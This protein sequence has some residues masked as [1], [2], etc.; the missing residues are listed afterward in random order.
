MSARTYTL[1]LPYG[2]VPVTVAERG[3][4]APVLLLHGGAGPDSFAGF[5]DELAARFGIHRATLSHDGARPAGPYRPGSSHLTRHPRVRHAHHAEK[6]RA[7]P[8]HDSRERIQT[9]DIMGPSQPEPA[10]QNRSLSRP[11]D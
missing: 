2:E 1:S 4:G 10:V 6:R 11:L 9:A 3:D 5:A 7:L 8:S